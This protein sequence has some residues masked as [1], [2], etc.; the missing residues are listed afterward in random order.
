VVDVLQSIL[1]LVALQFLHVA[2]NLCLKGAGKMQYSSSPNLSQYQ[3][4]M[5]RVALKAQFYVETRKYAACIAP[6]IGIN[7]KYVLPYF[8]CVIH[9]VPSTG[10]QSVHHVS[11]S[12]RD[13]R[14]VFCRCSQIIFICHFVS[15]Q[16]PWKSIKHCNKY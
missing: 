13:N 14:A 6:K 8:R 3:S 7:P 15:G 4:N 9:R 16:R 12:L 2:T 1:G 5:R 10:F 11:V